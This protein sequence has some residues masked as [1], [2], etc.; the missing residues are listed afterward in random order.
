MTDGV[1]G[2]GRRQPLIQ[3]YNIEAFWLR[4]ESAINNE[5]MPKMLGDKATPNQLRRQYYKV[6]AVYEQL[7]DNWEEIQEEIKR[8]AEHVKSSPSNIKTARE[9]SFAQFMATFDIKRKFAQYEGFRMDWEKRLS[10]LSDKLD[11]DPDRTS[12]STSRGGNH[13][14]RTKLPQISIPKFDGSIDQWFGFWENFRVLV[15]QQDGLTEIEKFNLLKGSLEGEAA[16]IIE[17]IPL[18]QDGYM[19]S[20]D[21]LLEK[22]GHENKL[23]RILNRDIVNLPIS[24][25]FEED[26]TLY[27]KIEKICR[28]LKSLNQSTDDTAYYMQLESKLS[29]IVLDKYMAI[30]SLIGDD[31][32]NTEQFRETFKKA[33][34]H[35]RTIREAR[36]ISSKSKESTISLKTSE[37]KKSESRNSHSFR[38]N[39]DSSNSE[40]SRS[41]SPGKFGN[42]P[43]KYRDKR[44]L[45]KRQYRSSPYPSS[46]SSSNSSS[47]SN[48]RDRNWPCAFC[49]NKH[50]EIDCE[51]FPDADS[52]R[53]RCLKKQ[54]CFYCLRYGHFSRECKRKYRCVFCRKFHNSALCRRKFGQSRQRSSSPHANRSK[55]PRKNDDKNV[56]PENSNLGNYLET[57]CKELSGIG[58]LVDSN[59]KKSILKVVNL[60]I[61]NPLMPKKRINK[62]CLLDDGS[63]KSYIEQ[64]LFEK[65]QLDVLETKTFQIY[66][67]TSKEVGTFK[68]P[69]VEFGIKSGKFE[70]LLKARV[71]PKVLNPMPFVS[72]KNISKEQLLRNKLI[73]E[74]KEIQPKILIGNDYYNQF[75]ISAKKKLPCGLWLSTSI[76]GDI[77][78]G[79]GKIKFVEIKNAKSS[80]LSGYTDES[81]SIEFI[82]DEKSQFKWE[83]HAMEQENLQFLGLDDSVEKSDELIKSEM[84]KLISYDGNRY[85]TG[86]LWND[87]V[88]QLPSNFDMAYAQLNNMLNKLR[89]EPK[90]LE[91]VNKIFLEQMDKGFIEKVP[92]EEINLEN[93]VIHYLPHHTVYKAHS[94]H[95]KARQVFNGSAKRN[96]APSLN[97][98]LEKGPMK[99]LYNDLVGIQIRA[100]FKRILVAADIAKAFLQIKLS[101]SDRDATRFFWTDN[102]FD[103]HAKIQH[104]RFTAVTFGIICSP[105]HLA[106]VIEIH[107]SKY[108]LEIAKEL[109]RNVYVDNLVFG[110]ENDEKILENCNLV[111]EIFKTAGMTVREFVSNSR[112]I[113]ELP[114]EDLI[115]KETTNF[116]GLGWNTVNDEFCIKF[117][118]F[119]PEEKLTKRKILSHAAK[120]FDPMGLVSPIMLGPKLFRQKIEL[121][122][123]LKWDK[124]LSEEQCEEWKKLV[125]DWSG[126]T[127]KIK[128]LIHGTEKV[129]KYELHAFCD[130][131]ILAFGIAIYIRAITQSKIYVKL[132]FG[133]S[134][135]VP[136]TVPHKRRTIPNLELHGAFLC[137]K[138][139]DFLMKELS[140]EIKIENSI[141]WTDS[142]DILDFLASP[143][144]FDVFVK[145]RINKIR[146]YNVRHIEGKLNPADIASRGANLEELKT[147]QIWWYGPNFLNCGE[148]YWPKSI[149]IYNPNDL[150]DKEY[151]GNIIA[152]LKTEHTEIK[153]ENVI[154]KLAKESSSWYRLKLILGWILKWKYKNFG[155]MTTSDLKKAEIVIYRNMQNLYPPSKLEEH[156]LNV[157]VDNNGLIR[158][159]GRIGKSGL[160]FDA[161]HPIYLSRK[162]PIVPLIIVD[163]HK[164]LLHGGV[165]LINCYIRQKIWIPKSRKLIRN[166]IFHNPLTKCLICT[167]FK[168]KPYEYPRAPE[169]PK[170]RSSGELAFS[171]VG[172]DYFG[173]FNVKGLES[174]KVWGAIFT[175]LLSRAIHLE[176]VSDCSTEKFLMAFR[177]F[178]RRRR[179]PNVILSDNGSNFILGAKV[180]AKIANEEV[181]MNQKWLKIYSDKKVLEFSLENNIDWKFNTPISPWRGGVFERMIQ[182]VKFHIKRVLGR[183][184]YSWEEFLTFLIE[185][186][187]IINERPITFVVNEEI[188]CPLKPIDILNP[189]SEK[190]EEIQFYPEIDIEIEKDEDFFISH[191]ATKNRDKILES[192]KKSLINVHKFWLEWKKTYLLELREKYEKMN[193]NTNKFPQIN[194]IVIIDEGEK[195]PRSFWKIG[196]I[197]KIISDRTV[198]VDLGNKKV[199][200]RPTKL[201]YPLEIE[202]ESEENKIYENQNSK[203]INAEFSHIILDRMAPHELRQKAVFITDHNPGPLRAI[204]AERDLAISVYMPQHWQPNL[205]GKDV[206]IG[207]E[208]RKIIVF[209]RMDENDSTQ[210]VEKLGSIGLATGVEV[211][212]IRRFF[213]RV[214]NV[215]TLNTYGALDW[216]VLMENLGR[217]GVEFEKGNFIEKGSSR[218]Q[219]QQNFG[220][221]RGWQPNE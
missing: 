123:N 36:P 153:S 85:E 35:I 165:D 3:E 26:E 106:L 115:L 5:E 130:A 146:N 44:D 42:N 86:L 160:N 183:N 180:L 77:V 143:R 78:N 208:V 74:L 66:G 108:P 151:L 193:R 117:P 104:F 148:E 121:S 167:K 159:K 88:K 118:I 51:R 95:T 175:C 49:K 6:K 124:P 135:I 54:L 112:K 203:N 209:K 136:K 65:L 15:H 217:S 16:E 19:D 177:R 189:N 190:S 199:L 84:C 50:L 31:N 162:S 179:C 57:N 39:R 75:L 147:N 198:L 38:P 72:L 32:W 21:L 140:K 126:E 161:I 139:V 206:I 164:S 9:D 4:I 83:K 113:S 219:Q 91:Q 103:E 188:V 8:A 131:S 76:V 56:N 202:V 101:S 133:K 23:I 213:R 47:R 81:E 27:L 34:N 216:N 119:K 125:S 194:Q 14:I 71:L 215:R 63:Q 155:R 13:F 144:K 204:A 181:E 185:V 210:L 12:Q 30:K 173:P 48:S 93:R 169:L 171:N 200:E 10:L 186:E 191:K 73:L 11:M 187:R 105:A 120:C 69:I 128:R 150:E 55:S 220:S 59:E 207:R 122:Q 79:E 163:A 82:N 114:K 1:D 43:Q 68:R 197:E 214:P 132:I 87:L 96:G 28:L 22:F 40:S 18:T 138:Y 90:I 192:Y 102:P 174:K 154:C 157:F 142:A 129:E 58:C 52:R 37:L 41:H 2:G 145:N 94:E 100:R 195:C 45:N 137:T 152:C 29:P 110:L 127:I 46:R 24:E 64:S 149:K 111:K 196:R 158:A 80:E 184:L 99:L 89:H 97:E 70:K 67:L 201:V 166:V 221:K 141:I 109:Q 116:L 98:C 212:W 134:L 170:F 20:I 61:F 156:Q 168:C 17:G 172:I 92:L 205:I 176:L 211:I 218:Q 7:V 178:I 25:S 53:D 182:S 107:L 33:L 60:E 62:F